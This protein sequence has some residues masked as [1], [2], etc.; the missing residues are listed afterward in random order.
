MPEIY[1]L[2]QDDPTNRYMI[3]A[4]PIIKTCAFISYHAD[5]NVISPDK[6][7]KSRWRTVGSVRR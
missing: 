1:L 7:D 4:L 6:S 2:I 5:K 3:S